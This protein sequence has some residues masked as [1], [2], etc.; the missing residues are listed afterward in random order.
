MSL[1]HPAPSTQVFVLPGWQSS[2]PE[3]WQSRWEALYGYT[4]VAQHDWQQ[5]KSGDWQIQLEE[6]I[7]A[8]P[9]QH[10]IVLVAHSLGCQLVARWASHSH[11]SWRVKAALLVA[12]PDT[13]TE[14]NR[15]LLPTWQPITTQ[16]LPFASRVL[17]SR[18]DPFCSLARAEWMAA[19]WGARF[20][21]AGALGHINIDSGLGDW[22]AGH[23]VLQQLIAQAHTE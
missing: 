7:L 18:N 4:R 3:H 22:A 13:E 16:R 21:D 10:S 11:H 19:Q 20:E 8:T 12:P 15:H 23:Q 1:L 5:P 2:G 17:A 14:Q 6:A 9:E